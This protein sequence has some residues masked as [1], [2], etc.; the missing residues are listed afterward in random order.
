[1]DKLLDKDGE[2]KKYTMDKYSGSYYR[3]NKKQE[4][5]NYSTTA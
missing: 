1:M 3:Y 5:P 2:L 4:Q